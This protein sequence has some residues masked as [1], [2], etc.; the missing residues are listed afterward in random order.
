MA[1]VD[2][3]EVRRC[4]CTCSGVVS[5]KLSPDG[6]ALALLVNNPDTGEDELSICR[7][8]F[9]PDTVLQDAT[10]ETVAEENVFVSS[11]ESLSSSN[12][13]SSSTNFPLSR[14]AINPAGQSEPDVLLS[15]PNWKCL[16]FFWSPDSSKLLFLSSFR[17]S[18][19]GTCR[20]G[21][22]DLNTLK[23]AKYENFI[24]S[25]MFAH[26]LTFF[27]SYSNSMTPWSPESDAFC[28]AG[29]EMTEEEKKTGEAEDSSNQANAATLLTALMLQK[30]KST[31]SG[32]GVPFS[33]CVQSVATLPVDDE[34]G[35]VL[36]RKVIVRPPRK[37]MDHVELAA[38]SQC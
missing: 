31:E 16:A 30:K 1:D 3:P 25:P 33:A 26:S 24:A 18:T 4:I 8:D 6:S 38:W 29:R 35:E 37:I 23:V 5:F 15:T 12:S 28:Y 17:K 36:S 20:W 22:F 34:T 9:A 11:A 14:M 2:N 13:S 10:P 19:V 32:K 21:T 27:C 7:G